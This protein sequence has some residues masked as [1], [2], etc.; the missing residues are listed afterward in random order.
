MWRRESDLAHDQLARPLIRVGG[1]NSADAP[2]MSGDVD[3]T[4]D[5]VITDI[6][7]Q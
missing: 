4:D 3:P 6:L 5:K 2:I 1:D 7:I